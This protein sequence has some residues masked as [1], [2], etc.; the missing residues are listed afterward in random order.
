[1]SQVL[2][3]FGL[4]EF[5]HV[6]ARSRLARVLKL[7]NRLF[8][9]FIF[10]FSGRGKPRILNQRIWGHCCMCFKSSSGEVRKI[11]SA[12]LQHPTYFLSF[13][14]DLIKICVRVFHSQFY[15]TEFHVFLNR[16]Q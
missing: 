8:I 3:A 4:P 11:Q 1:M 2:G 10:I 9:Y 12:K 14:Y 15:R 13:K 16:C 6:T 5:H 7:T